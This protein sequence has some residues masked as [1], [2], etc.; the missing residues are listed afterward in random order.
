MLDT[1]NIP[2][3]LIYCK[4]V[5][6]QLNLCAFFTFVYI[7]RHTVLSNGV[8]QIQNVKQKDVGSYSCRT[9]S[10]LQDFKVKKSQK[11]E[12][13]II[14]GM[15]SFTFFYLTFQKVIGCAIFFY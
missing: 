13:N 6:I 10:Q 9:S 8:L 7:H 12:L 1:G 3:R 11:A 2:T 4:R 14:S 15:F 5:P